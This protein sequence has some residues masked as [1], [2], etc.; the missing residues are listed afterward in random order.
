MTTHQ[1]ALTFTLLRCKW[2]GREWERRPTGRDRRVAYCS[3]LCKLQHWN[4][5]QPRRDCVVCGVSVSAKAKYCDACRLIARSASNK[6][7]NQR[8]QKAH[9]APKLHRL[10]CQEC[11]GLF[12]VVK[13]TRKYCSRQCSIKG[14]GKALRR[15]LSERAVIG[16]D[17]RICGERFSSKRHTKKSLCK[18]CTKREYRNSGGRSKGESH[19]QRARRN[20]VQAENISRIAVFKRD[21]W[22]CGICG[23]DTPRSL[24]KDCSHTYSPTLDHVVPLS[25]GGSHTVDN[26]QCLCRGCNSRKGD[27]P[28]PT[29]IDEVLAVMYGRQYVGPILS[30]LELMLAGLASEPFIVGGG[31]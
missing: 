22:R 20:C 13:N 11:S 31:A 10:S 24:L 8:L 1:L 28:H 7:I 16:L 27:R 21:G 4:A 29:T 14:Q 2:C 17:C 6:A 23:V 3:K 9:K 26:V 18:R 19:T 30:H 12:T 15:A 5:R 25:K